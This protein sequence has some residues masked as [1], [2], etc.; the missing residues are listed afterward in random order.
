MFY[1]DSK[2][3]KLQFI[4]KDD[5]KL[6]NM[7]FILECHKFKV[8]IIMKIR[9]NTHVFDTIQRLYIVPLNIKCDFRNMAFLI[10]EEASL[11]RLHLN[12]IKHVG[13][14]SYFQYYRY[15]ELMTL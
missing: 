3:A 7:V 6:L 15:F 9:F 8:T 11:Q 10:V 14:K 4:R 2:L 13:I 5:W 1:I 12:G